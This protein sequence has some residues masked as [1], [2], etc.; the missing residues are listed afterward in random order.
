MHSIAIIWPVY[1]VAHD[2]SNT[3]IRKVNQS[4]LDQIQRQHLM[5]KE[6]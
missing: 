6:Q 5:M 1:L 3:K 2:Q 4:N